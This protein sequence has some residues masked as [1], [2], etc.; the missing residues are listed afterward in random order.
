MMV[1]WNGIL[2]GSMLQAFE[3]F[4]GRRNCEGLRMRR[5]LAG[6]IS[7][8]EEDEERLTGIHRQFKWEDQRPSL[9]AYKDTRLS[10]R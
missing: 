5:P 9:G 6:T 7:M 8:L 1:K 10:C 2:V 3:R 4:R